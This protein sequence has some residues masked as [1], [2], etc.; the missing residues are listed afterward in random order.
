MTNQ[1]GALEPGPRI[2][3]RA[4][5]S[6]FWTL[7][8]G[9]RMKMRTMAAAAALALAAGGGA[10]A[11]A[12]AASAATTGPLQATVYANGD[13]TAQWSGYGDPVLKAGTAPGTS[14]QVDL[15]GAYAGQQA[16]T[17]EPSFNASSSGAGDPRWV[18]ELHNGCYVFGYPNEPG[19]T[20]ANDWS[21]NPGG[22]QGVSYATAIAAAK[23]CGSDNWVTSAFIVDDAGY[24][25]HTVT[26][27]NVEY[28][29]QYLPN[30]DTVTGYSG[31]KLGDAGSGKTDGTAV[32]LWTSDGTP[33]QIWTVEPDG[34][35]VN[36]A[37]GTGMCLDD[38]GFGGQGTAV[39]M[40][41]CVQNGQSNEQW[42]VSGSHLV[43]AANGLCLNDAGYG[44]RGTQQI[45]W[46]CGNYANENYTQP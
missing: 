1:P 8:R 19:Y 35:V 18:I 32:V 38:P 21:V 42:Y 4:D 41:Q 9:V 43:N 12:T 16:P 3:V 39:D 45:L 14:A 20:S 6:Q 40:Y 27:T 11:A 34:A 37:A 17:M 23:A 13:S 33:D 7:M 15:S 2:E 30:P 5:E 36:G 10:V 22:Q 46:A 28:D 26:L 25:G 29:N 44:A 24:N 31:L